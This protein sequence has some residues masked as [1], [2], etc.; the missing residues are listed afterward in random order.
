LPRVVH[1]KEGSNSK[2]QSDPRDLAV[3]VFDQPVKCITPAQLAAQGSLS[4]LPTDQQFT[5]VGYG[6]PSITNSPGGKTFHY[7]DTRYGRQGR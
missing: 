6:A 5:S 4:D 7:Q 3:V 2:S 1:A